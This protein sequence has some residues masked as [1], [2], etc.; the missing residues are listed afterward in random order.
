M[1]D[2]VIKDGVLVK[3]S[4][5]GGDVTV[6]DGV[7]EIGDSVFRFNGKLRTVTLPKSVTV[8]GERAFGN[9]MALTSVNLH[10]GITKIG[11]EAFTY[12]DLTEVTIPEGVTEIDH[13]TF[14][15]CPSLRDV[16]IHAGVTKISYSAF[17]NTPKLTLHVVRGSE[18]ES[19]FREY[20]RDAIYPIS[21]TVTEPHL[22]KKPIPIFEEDTA[23][24]KSFLRRLFG[25]K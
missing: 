1:S 24:K 4:G 8:I 7:T 17:R 23:P 18:G 19:F 13:E 14:R 9:C 11:R 3:Y 20:N 25:G 12:T 15:G 16:T 2:F 21:Y 5:D 6:P 22:P 10:D